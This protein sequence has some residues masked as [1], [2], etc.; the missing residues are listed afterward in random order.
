MSGYVNVEQKVHEVI[1][2]LAEQKGMKIYTLVREL[3]K[4]YIKQN[5]IELP[6]DKNLDM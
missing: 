1:K 3:V 4:A 5:K 2:W 6:K